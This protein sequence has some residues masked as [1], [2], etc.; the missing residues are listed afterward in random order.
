MTLSFNEKGVAKFA[1]ASA[2]VVVCTVWNKFAPQETV[3]FLSVGLFCFFLICFGRV[4]W[5]FTVW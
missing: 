2:V 4:F 1:A 5:M 3:E